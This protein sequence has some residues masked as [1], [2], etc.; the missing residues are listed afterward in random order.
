MVN[1]KVAVITGASKGIGK[2]CAE[3][4]LENGYIVIDAS[5]SNPNSIENRYY[6][7]Y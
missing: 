3:L 5:R 6:Y 4:F 7:L 1:E 2:A